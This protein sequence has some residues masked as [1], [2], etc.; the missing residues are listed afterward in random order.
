MEQTLQPGT[1]LQGGKYVIKQVLGQGGFGITYLARQVS[2]GRD[3]AIK[4]FFMQDNNYRNNNGTTVEVVDSKRQEF[5][6]QRNKFGREAKRMSGLRNPHIV[7]VIDLFD[8]NGTSYYAMDYIDGENLKERLQ[9]TG[10]SMSEAEVTGVLRQVLDALQTVHAQG[11]WH[12]DIKPSN[13]MID[14][15]GVVRLI[16]FGASKQLRRNSDEVSTVVAFTEAY[17][18]PEQITRSYEKFGPWTD[19][20]ALGATLYNL[21]TRCQPPS[22]V[23]I[24]TQEKHE[25][26]KMPQVSG[27]MRDLIMWMMSPVYSDRPA[28]VHA[29]RDV[30]STPKPVSPSIGKKSS[31]KW[32]VL[33]A[34]A[35]VLAAAG[36][37]YALNRGPASN[38]VED[39]DDFEVV[40]SAAVAEMERRQAE[41]AEQARQDSID[42]AERH[43]QQQVEQ[44]IDAYIGVLNS[45]KR[46]YEEDLESYFNE[47]FLQDLN[48]DGLP[49][50]CVTAGTCEAD[51]KL[52]VYTME[53]GVATLLG[54][55]GF[56][57]SSAY[58]G[59]NCI[60]IFG[61]HMGYEWATKVTCINNNFR[62]TEIS[63]SIDAPDE[64]TYKFYN[65]AP[66]R[67]K[68]K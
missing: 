22:L 40:D 24:T 16:D 61:T 34:V 58:R 21:L 36:G 55:T 67:S 3:V 47:Y 41:E 60:L 18:P 42:R 51:R 23:D 57:H 46:E 14:K 49:E 26:F 9:R 7:S 2:L 38:P 20:Y 1:L 4:E 59:D 53:D 50:L 66:L 63:T 25:A 17:S 12:M 28:S 27:K 15:T 43:H 13:L 54:K 52:L 68:I 45:L 10:V 33:L 35:A 44:T 5:D 48:G 30:L 11:I 6:E 64:V 65:T 19:F 29:I 39:E 8:E 37:I 62:E 31:S 56:D 32:W